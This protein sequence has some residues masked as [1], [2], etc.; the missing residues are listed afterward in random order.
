[1][2]S[3]GRRYCS[4]LQPRCRAHP[5]PAIRP[6]LIHPRRLALKPQVHFLRQEGSRAQNS[7]TAL[8]RTDARDPSRSAAEAPGSSSEGVKAG[9]AWRRCR[10][11]IR[12]PVPPGF[13]AKGVRA[14]SGNP[15]WARAQ[16]QTRQRAGF[17]APHAGP[18]PC[19]AAGSGQ[20]CCPKQCSG[21]GF[22]FLINDPY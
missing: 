7:S 13:P 12:S 2:G 1:M 19:P 16:H 11:C 14:P 18:A 17:E 8:R 10:G 20:L 21:Y 9:A 22:R 15:S 3:E 6:A 4:G 5:S